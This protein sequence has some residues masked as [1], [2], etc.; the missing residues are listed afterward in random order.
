MNIKINWWS[1]LIQYWLVNSSIP[2]LV[3]KFEDLKQD[4]VR[5]VKRIL[6]FINYHQL[7]QEELSLKIKDGFK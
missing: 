1:K 4:P 3:V 7:T 6:D 2:V 5:E